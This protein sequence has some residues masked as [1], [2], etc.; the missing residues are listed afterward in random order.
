MQLCDLWAVTKEEVV[1]GVWYVE[2]KVGP[3]HP[4]IR[5]AVTKD[6]GKPCGQWSLIPMPGAVNHGR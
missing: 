1:E 5:Y 4:V 2:G 6:P 3:G